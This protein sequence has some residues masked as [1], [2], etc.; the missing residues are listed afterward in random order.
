M[1]LDAI[2]MMLLVLGTIWGG[3]VF[4]LWI[5]MKREQKKARE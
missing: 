2:L 5:A 3:F 4:T 1:T